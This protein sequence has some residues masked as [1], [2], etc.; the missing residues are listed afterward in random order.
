MGT[1]IRGGE[2]GFNYSR[3]KKDRSKRGD[4]VKVEFHSPNYRGIQRLAG[5]LEVRGQEIEV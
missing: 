5:N 2:H 1:E 3:L 4:E